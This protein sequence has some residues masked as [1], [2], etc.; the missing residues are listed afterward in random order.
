MTELWKEALADCETV[1]KF[2]FLAVATARD[3]RKTNPEFARL[4]VAEAR[5]RKYT[6]MGDRD[7]GWYV[8]VTPEEHVA[9]MDRLKSIEHRE[10]RQRMRKLLTKTKVELVSAAWEVWVYGH[11]DDLGAMLI[12]DFRKRKDNRVIYEFDQVPKD[13]YFRL[14]TKDAKMTLSN[15]YKMF[16]HQL[17]PELRNWKEAI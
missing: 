14:F 16:D 7:S 8:D 2:N 12:T 5:R 17:Q 13:L 6:W 4:V 1:E 3:Q 15:I 10:Q 9:M 11:G